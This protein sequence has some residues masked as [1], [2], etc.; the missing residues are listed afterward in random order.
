MTTIYDVARAAGVSTTTVS[1]VLNGTRHVNEETKNRV[2]A[3]ISR[4]GYQPSSLARALVVQETQTIALVVPDSVQFFFAELARS[5]E[6]YAF[7]AGYNVI[8][9]QSENNEAKERAHLNMLI[10]KRVDG[11]VHMTT[12]YLRPRVEVLLDNRIPVVTFDRDYTGSGLLID[13]V[14]IENRQGAYAATRHMVELGHR[15]LACIHVPSGESR[16]RLDGFEQALR[17]AGLP[18]DPALI[19][20]GEWSLE[21]GWQAAEQLLAL[22]DPPTGIFTSND[23]L[24]IGA[25]GCL[26]DHGIDVPRDMSVV[27]FDD[28]AL[29]SYC[30]P[31]LTTYAT[32]IA[33]VGEKLCQLLFDRI[34]GSLPPTIQQVWVRG[35]L[36]VR[37]STAPPCAAH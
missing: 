37:K 26:R 35:E 2:Q 30:A 14:R 13:S 8:L 6:S 25:I 32:P 34:N 21:S 18:I 23:M 15:R 10:S 12:D 1:H 20:N 31:L 24:A 36:K 29:A 22:A 28:I 27:G 33:E 9:C 17:E 5:V 11:V 7:A 4:L 3:A 19:V 16:T